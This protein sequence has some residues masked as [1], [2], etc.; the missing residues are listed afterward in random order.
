MQVVYSDSNADLVL[1]T[2]KMDDLERSLSRH[3]SRLLSLR[4]KLLHHNA[5][6]LLKFIHHNNLLHTQPTPSQLDSRHFHANNDRASVGGSEGVIGSN[7]DSPSQP[8]KGKAVE[9]TKTIE[10]INETVLAE[11]INEATHAILSENET[12][13]QRLR[14]HL[15][16]SHGR[17]TQL[18]NAVQQS[19]H[20]KQLLNDAHSAH[21]QQSQHSTNLQ[22]RLQSLLDD[23]SQVVTMRDGMTSSLDGLCGVLD[24]HHVAYTR[25]PHNPLDTFTSAI[26]SIEAQLMLNKENTSASEQMTYLTQEKNTM[27]QRFD[28]YENQMQQLSDV[29]ANQRLDMETQKQQWSSVAGEQKHRVTSLEEELGEANMRIRSMEADVAFYKDS[30]AAYERELKSKEDSRHSS[31]VSVSEEKLSMQALKGLWK[32]LPNSSHRPPGQ[33]LIDASSA[34]LAQ[35]DIDTLKQV[36]E[37]WKERSFE[38]YDLR[39]FVGCVRTLIDDNR[40][41]IERI[42][43]NAETANLY[44]V[45][46]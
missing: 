1:S 25:H 9:K 5:A 24:S 19:A 39:A 13:Q 28:Y 36:L 30:N 22:S 45:G 40:F 14:E 6:I 18:D 26:A 46:F 44:K 37:R 3:Y 4:T 41:F 43:H 27:R 11:R 7:D 29:I 42:L 33:R 32:V 34:A 2:A 17:T 38:K 8:S 23:F 20:Y 16:E 31:G 10:T 21:T 35:T 15:E 12:L